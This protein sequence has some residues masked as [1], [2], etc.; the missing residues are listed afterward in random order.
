MRGW[1]S[2]NQIGEG[3]HYGGLG[4]AAGTNARV[5]QQTRCVTHS[6][7][8]PVQYMHASYI[9]F[10]LNE[11]QQP[12]IKWGPEPCKYLA[13]ALLLVEGLTGRTKIVL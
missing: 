13:P 1:R 6:K 10:T 12:R 5:S 9:N 4:A 11:H 8:S 2:G 3:T 7:L